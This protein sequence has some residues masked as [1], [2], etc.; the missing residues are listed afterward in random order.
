MK[1]EYNL[2]EWNDI[3]FHAFSM[4]TGILKWKPDV[5]GALEHFGEAGMSRIHCYRTIWTS[6]LAALNW[7][8]DRWLVLALL[9][10][11]TFDKWIRDVWIMTI[12]HLWINHLVAEEWFDSAFFIVGN[13]LQLHMLFVMI[14]VN[15][16]ESLHSFVFNF[17]YLVLK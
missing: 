2:N 17:N 6:P 16:C 11:A 4:K 15:M 1:S 14:V 9:F 12:T 8:L 5:E 7:D 13:I 3:I 10:A